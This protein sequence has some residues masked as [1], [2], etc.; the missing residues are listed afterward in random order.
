M[1]PC[2]FE[3]TS[4]TNTARSPKLSCKAICQG[5]KVFNITISENNLRF[6]ACFAVFAFA[7]SSLMAGQKGVL[8]YVGIHSELNVA[9]E[10]LE[11]LSAEKNVIHHRV[12]RLRSASVDPDMADEQARLLLSYAEPDEIV[13]LLEHDGVIPQMKVRQASI[14]QNLR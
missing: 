13:V 2:Y 9:E 8:S 4:N 5:L 14:G 7:L 6:I 1:N 3:H 10:R 12:S 11:A